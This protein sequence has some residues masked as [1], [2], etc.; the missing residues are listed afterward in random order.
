MDT[1]RRADLHLHSNVSRDVP[2]VAS[3]SPRGLFEKALGNPDPQKRMDY[4]ALT[5]HDTMDGYRM[6]VRELSE[7]DQRLVIPGVEHAL[8]DPGIGFSIH[9]N[10]YLIDPDTYHDLGRKVV[11]IDDLLGFCREHDI[12]AQYNHPT[13]FEH[14]EVRRRQVD[15][16]VVGRIAERFPV[17]ELNGGRL[18]RQNEITKLLAIS[19]GKTLT[20]GSDSHSGDVGSSHSIASG[21]TAEAF[22]HNIWAGR[23]AVHTVDM[24]RTSML[25][26]VHDLIDAILDDDRCRQPVASMLPGH[27]RRLE[28]LALGLF[29]APFMRRP[30]VGRRMLRVLLKQ[31]SVPVVAAWLEQENRVA[32]RMAEAVQDAAVHSWQSESISH[33]SDP[34]RSGFHKNQRAA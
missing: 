23:G 2:D 18:H 19:Q 3:L 15:F 30:G 34:S 7:T 14:A 9:V 4:F 27:R 16:G 8:Y 6:L 25:R 26:V 1:P 29:N 24:T 22:L 12:L 21:E 13:W 31:I 11:T 28:D 20:A 10:L 17:L 5:D 32:R 33:S